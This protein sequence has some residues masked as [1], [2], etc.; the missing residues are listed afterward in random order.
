MPDSYLKLFHVDAINRKAT[1]K[2]GKKVLQ[3]FILLAE[4]A[5]ELYQREI[6]LPFISQ[7]FPFYRF[8][9]AIQRV[10]SE[11]TQDIIARINRVVSIQ[12]NC[13]LQL[14][15]AHVDICVNEQAGNLA[16]KAQKSPQL[17]NNL[18]LTD[19]DATARHKLTS[20]PVK[21]LFIPGLNCN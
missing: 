16:K 21:K 15:P 11:L 19:V 14:I 20:H 9:Q 5:L 18:T 2:I 4:H 3:G 8:R 1:K 17:S 7:N 13:S 10:N 6:L 12:R